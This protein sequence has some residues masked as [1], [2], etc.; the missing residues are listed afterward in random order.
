MLSR[1]YSLDHAKRSLKTL[2]ERI[3][4]C[5]KT[6]HDKL[7]VQGLLRASMPFQLM[8]LKKRDAELYNHC[9]NKLNR[10]LNGFCIGHYRDKTVLI[11]DIVFSGVELAKYNAQSHYVTA[12]MKTLYVSALMDNNCNNY[13]YF[14][15]RK[16]FDFPVKNMVIYGIDE[17]GLLTN[18]PY[19]EVTL[20]TLVSF[21]KE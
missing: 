17:D 13:V 20:N 12:V 14:G 6:T 21:R 18:C 1:C 2:L 8:L 5:R 4:A 15:N 16:W 19:N 11:H 3:E 7:Q 10:S 9:A